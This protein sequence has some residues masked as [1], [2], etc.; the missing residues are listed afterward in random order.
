M[1]EICYYALISAPLLPLL[2]S[3]KWSKPYERLNHLLET[4]RYQKEIMAG[5]MSAHEVPERYGLDKIV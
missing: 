3:T 2:G 5:R 1:G 4:V